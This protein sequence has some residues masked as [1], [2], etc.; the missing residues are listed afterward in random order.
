MAL[1]VFVITWQATTYANTSFLESLNRLRAI[2]WMC[3]AA[4][5]EYQQQRKL[6]GLACWQGNGNRAGGDVL[7]IYAYL[8]S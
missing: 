4:V 3:P 2:G 8:V 1:C 7:I 5:C 6:S